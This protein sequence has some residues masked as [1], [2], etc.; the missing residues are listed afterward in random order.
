MNTEKIA[1][2]LAKELNDNVEFINSIKI[3]NDYIYFK[4]YK[5]SYAARLTKTGKIKRHSV[6]LYLV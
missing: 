2:Q 5:T 4:C 6:T 1:Q 3:I